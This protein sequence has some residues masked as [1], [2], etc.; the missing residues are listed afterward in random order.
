MIALNLLQVAALGGFPDKG[1]F[2]A[3][4]RDRKTAVLLTGFS[5]FEEIQG[6]FRCGILMPDGHSANGIGRCASRQ[7]FMRKAKHGGWTV[8]EA[9]KGGAQ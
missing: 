7:D 4:N 6:V 8:L 1:V 3:C 5:C 2:F 9:E